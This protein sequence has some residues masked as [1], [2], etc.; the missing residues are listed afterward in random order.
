[1]KNLVR[2]TVEVSRRDGVD[3]AL[4]EYLSRGWVIVESWIVGYGDPNERIETAHFLLGWIDRN[5][6]PNHPPKDDSYG[7]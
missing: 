4:N 6:E 7:F 3:K 2:E 5:S 1:M